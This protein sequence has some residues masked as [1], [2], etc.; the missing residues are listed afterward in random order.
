MNGAKQMSRKKPMAFT[1][2]RTFPFFE[3][4]YVERDDGNGVIEVGFI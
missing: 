1:P 2:Y 3:V 4:K